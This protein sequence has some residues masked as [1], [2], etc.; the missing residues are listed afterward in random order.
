[1]LR[2]L[3]F[4]H[5]TE[6]DQEVSQSNQNSRPQMGNHD[7][8]TAVTIRASRPSSSLLQHPTQVTPGELPGLR[9]R[10]RPPNPEG[11]LQ[12]GSNVPGRAVRGH[13]MLRRPPPMAVPPKPYNA[14]KS[15][16]HEQNTT[17]CHELKKSLHELANKDQIDH[18]LNKAPQNE[19][20]H[21]PS[22]G[23]R[24]FSKVVA[25]IAGRYAEG[26]TRSA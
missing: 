23:I 6:G 22:R 20:P 12:A 2:T 1:M 10:S 9:R 18:F 8:L 11:E 5:H 13:P 24:V 19:S 21:S 25:T 3:P 16:F 26:M 4:P 14:R 7:Q 15:C 17:E